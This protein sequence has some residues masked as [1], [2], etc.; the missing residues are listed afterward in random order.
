MSRTSVRL[1]GYLVGMLSVFG[2]N[3]DVVELLLGEQ[4]MRLHALEGARLLDDGLPRLGADR[5]GKIHDKQS[6]VGGP[7]Q[8]VEAVKGAPEGF[9][10]AL[11]R[12]GPVARS[13]D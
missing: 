9:R 5:V 10:D 7:E 1:A 11:Y 8:P 3:Q 12:Y 13:V 4:L 6:V 2:Q